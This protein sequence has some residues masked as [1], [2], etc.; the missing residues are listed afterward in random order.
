MAT[1]N[2]LFAAAILLG[3]IGGLSACG[4]T[5][6][7]RSPAEEVKQLINLYENARPKFVVQKQKMVQASSCSRATRLRQAID[8]MAED[9]AMSAANTDTITVVQMELQQAEKDCLAK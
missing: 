2:K 8:S 1:M 5:K 4:G 9:A 7:A 6:A 3:C